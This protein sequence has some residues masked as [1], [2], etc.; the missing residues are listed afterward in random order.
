[1]SHEFG[2][3]LLGAKEVRTTQSVSCFSLFT[4]EKCIA[5]PASRL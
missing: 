5:V 2:S 4:K 3:E 1:M